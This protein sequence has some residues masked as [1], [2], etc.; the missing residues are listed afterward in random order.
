MSTSL[1]EEDKMKINS[2]DE[3][4]NKFREGLDEAN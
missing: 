4:W 3:A 2:L 1:T